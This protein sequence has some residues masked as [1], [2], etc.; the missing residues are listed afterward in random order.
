MSWPGGRA[1]CPDVLDHLA[2]LEGS[3]GR[4]Q[5]GVY[6]HPQSEERRLPILSVSSMG[7]R[8]HQGHQ[9]DESS[10]SAFSLLQFLHILCH[11]VTVEL[12]PGMVGG[13]AL[14]PWQN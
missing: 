2:V 10:K 11:L 9:L 4:A 7:P 3:S 5:G 13:K 12:A 1:G 6:R 14:M 8:H